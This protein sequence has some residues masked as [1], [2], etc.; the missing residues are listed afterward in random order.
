MSAHG[1]ADDLDSLGVMVGLEIHQQLATGRK[2]FCGCPPDEPD[3]HPIT[4]RRRLRSSSGELGWHD[5]AALFEGARARTVTYYAN[6]NSS[7][8]VEMDEEPPHSLDA[9]AKR[10]A[11][12]I[13]SALKSRIYTELHP[14]RKTV[15]DGSNTAGFQRT[16]LVSE[17]GE[18]DVLLGGDDS[19]GESGAPD[20]RLTVGV[21][22][23]C[24]EEDAAKILD[25][26]GAGA[27][28]AA[29]DAATAAATADDAATATAAGYGLERL[30]VPLVEIATE[31]F[32]VSDPGVVRAVALSL[33]RILRGTR[34]VARGLGSIRQDVNVSIRDGGGT[35]VEVKGVQRL[36]QLRDVV[37][38]EARRQHGLLA[39]S[40]RLRES[41]WSHDAAR[42][43]ADATDA[44]RGS[45]SRIV[46]KALKKPDHMI[47][48]VAFRKAVGIFGYSPHADVRLGREVAELARLFG[49]GGIFHSDEL[50]AYGMTE[51]DVAGVAGLLQA[52]RGRDAFL[53]LAAPRARAGAIVD[54]MIS[55][56]RRI[57]EA[58]IPADTRL[59]TADG[60]TAFMRPR[61]GA[62][63]MY[64]ETDVPTIAITQDEL[65]DAAAEVPRSWDE[66]VY[67]M[68]AKYEISAQLAE[69]L[70]DSS[71]VELFEDVVAKHC[72]EGRSGNGGGQGQGG[73]GGSI[74]PAFVASVLCSSITG[75]GRQEGLDAG[76]LDD[77]AVREAFGLLDRQEIAKESIDIIFQEIMSGRAGTVAEAIKSASIRSMGRAEL[78]DVIRGIIRDNM[79]MVTNQRERA[80]GPLMGIAMR[81][82]RGRA[83]GKT[84]NALVV[85][86]I[87]EALG[88]G[89][90]GGGGEQGRRDTSRGA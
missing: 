70:W 71:R 34:M 8:L 76:L 84:V 1:K 82:L 63:R 45:A 46:Q 17:G 21:Q 51:Q 19:G 48:A 28:A 90:G 25:A 3:D 6:P 30:G 47:M 78:E 12:V 52:D 35:V 65:D 86:G 85:G 20:N 15:V 79:G 39:I 10:A 66:M 22:S 5:P 2:L 73:E 37:L 26:K 87:A 61:P 57:A 36:E 59:A 67:G 27:A 81:K 31:P 11:L 29:A 32:R 72:K 77:D 53:M 83:P 24:L 42:D 60:R 41:G 9:G 64:P 74:S 69:Q 49:V 88:R 14:M 54:Q 18:F 89:R 38:Y 68:Q 43:R 56:V 62:A 58:R 40:R 44:L 75:L 33:G 13:A 80:A 7:C 4:F 16:M 23:V 55:R 50:P